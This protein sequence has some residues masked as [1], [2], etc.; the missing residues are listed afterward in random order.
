M[1]VFKRF[2]VF[3]LTVHKRQKEPRNDANSRWPSG[4][5]GLTKVTKINVDFESDN[6]TDC[7]RLPVSAQTSS[8]CVH[9]TIKFNL[10]LLCMN[11]L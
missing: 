11:G 6:R 2:M 8:I 7:H 10:F 5:N 4:T 3:P 1:T 9:N